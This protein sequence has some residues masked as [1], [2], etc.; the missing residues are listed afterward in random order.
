MSSTLLVPLHMGKNRGIYLTDDRSGECLMKPLPLTP[1]P[2]P[3]QSGGRPYA[4][5]APSLPP[6]GL[7][8]MLSTNLARDLQSS[9]P[10]IARAA[11]RR[12][13]LARRH[14]RLSQVVYLSHALVDLGWEICTSK[15]RGSTFCLGRAAK[16]VK[17]G[18]EGL[19]RL[20]RVVQKTFVEDGRALTSGQVFTSQREVA[21]SHMH[22]G[23]ES[24]LLSRQ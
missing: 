2:T 14:P 24:T 20:L 21:P 12:F 4:K 3:I 13:A 6:C 1:K 19:P 9:D 10:E 15:R 17:E 5:N 7:R 22:E 23:F 8:A 16:T 11:P 18:S